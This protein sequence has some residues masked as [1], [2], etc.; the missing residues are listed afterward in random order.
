MQK[1]WG[2]N[3][4][5][6]P[7]RWSKA[8]LQGSCS[9]GLPLITLLSKSFLNYPRQIPGLVCTEVYGWAHENPK[10]EQ[11]L[12]GFSMCHGAT[13]PMQKPVHLYNGQDDQKLLKTDTRLSVHPH[14]LRGPHFAFQSSYFQY[15]AISTVPV[16]LF[17]AYGKKPPRTGTVPWPPPQG[18][19]TCVPGQNHAAPRRADKHAGTTAIHSTQ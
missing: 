15:K 1:C 17:H 9:V 12:I 2:T 13:A 4:H 8:I 11:T 6:L 7:T 10:T 19:H 18:G 14:K 5:C 3:L 16:M